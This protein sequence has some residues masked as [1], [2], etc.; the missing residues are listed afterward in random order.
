MERSRDINY[1][2]P[3][4]IEVIDML[5]RIQ[6]TIEEPKPTKVSFLDSVDIPH[7]MTAGVYELADANNI[8]I[9]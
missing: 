7:N 6:L 3:Y 4:N 8:Y 1:G 2:R 5:Y 9:Y